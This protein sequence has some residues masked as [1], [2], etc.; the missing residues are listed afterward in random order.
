MAND[1]PNIVFIFS[2][3]HAPHAIGAYDGWL[4]SV[5]PTPNIDRLVAEGVAFTRAYTQSPICT[6]SRSSF[7]T[8]MYPSR[9]HNTRNGNESFPNQPPVITRRIADADR[10]VRR[11]QAAAGRGG[12]G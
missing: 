4:K 3:D 2:D 6:P 1:R 11:A 8:G 7:M 9:L 5:N 12:A 10:I